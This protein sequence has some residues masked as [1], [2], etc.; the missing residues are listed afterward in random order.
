M[1]VNSQPLEAWGTILNK[2]EQHNELMS[3]LPKDN[4][5]MMDDRTDLHFS[6]G[7]EPKIFRR[8]GMR[9]KTEIRV[10]N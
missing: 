1:T 4:C 9:Y 7:S 2:L 5:G 3:L 8:F 10:K 6:V